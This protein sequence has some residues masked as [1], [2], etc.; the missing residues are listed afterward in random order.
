MTDEEQGTQEVAPEVVQTEAEQVTAPEAAE[1]TEGQHE[2]AQPAKEAEAEKPEPAEDKEKLSRNQRRNARVAALREEAERLQADNSRLAAY[3][4]ELETSGKTP[5]PKQE[6]F[7]DYDEYMAARTAHASMAALDK[8]E[9]ER[10]RR[11]GEQ[12]Q[13]RLQRI[14]QERQQ[15]AQQN[16]VAQSADARTRYAD[17]DA[18]VTAPDVAITENMARSMAMGEHGADVAYHLGTNKDLS[19]EIAG[20]SPDQQAGAIA[21]LDRLI[22]QQ[23]PKPKTQTS[24][25]DP[26]TPVKATATGVGDPSKMSADE[27]D[28]WR[29]AGGT[30]KT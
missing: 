30:F 2:Q 14:E 25:P 12:Q 21:M 19:R 20:M 10:M 8:R 27:Y 6:D 18:V 11:Q 1:S 22:P 5:P 9:S 28:K 24:A 4:S 29:E 16:W 17:F 23:R 13:Q 26:V 7:A 3:I 15:E